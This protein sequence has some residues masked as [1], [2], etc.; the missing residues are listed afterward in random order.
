MLTLSLISER[1]THHWTSADGSIW[2]SRCGLQV[3]RHQLVEN[4]TGW[5][6]SRCGESY[7]MMGEAALAWQDLKV[8]E[9]PGG[10]VPMAHV[11]H[12]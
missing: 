12:K 8:N 9:A 6:C 5:L 7:R 2:H 4:T 10:M 11:E 1:I 3:Q